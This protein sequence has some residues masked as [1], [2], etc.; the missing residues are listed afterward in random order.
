MSAGAR[1]HAAPMSDP[2]EDVERLRR[3]LENERNERRTE[4]RKVRQLERDL[5]A[6]RQQLQQ[7]P[8]RLVRGLRESLSTLHTI[9]EDILARFPENPTLKDDE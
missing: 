6:C 5:E 2:S 3:A 7:S 1:A 4:A 8:P 9:I